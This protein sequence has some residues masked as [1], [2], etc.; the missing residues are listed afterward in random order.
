MAQRWNEKEGSLA[1]E[2]QVES[3]LK[4][5]RE[6]NDF[7]DFNPSVRGLFAGQKGKKKIIAPNASGRRAI[8]HRTMYR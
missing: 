1:Y 3:F 5:L 7:I 4:V 6:A 2:E 8:P